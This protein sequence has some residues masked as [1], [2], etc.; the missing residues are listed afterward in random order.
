[1]KHFPLSVQTRQALARPSALAQT[2]AP[3]RSAWRTIA[4]LILLVSGAVPRVWAADIRTL[5]VDEHQGRY[6][7]TYDAIVDAARDDVYATIT[8]PER[9]PQLS[10]VVTAARVTG[11]LPDGGREISVTLHTCILIFCQ[12]LHKQEALRISAGGNIETVVFPERSDFSYAYEH[13]QISG[14]G[15]RTRIR[16]HAEMTPKFYIVPLIGSYLLKAKIR[17][18]LQQVTASLEAQ[19]AP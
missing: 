15:R 6:T 13:W 7:V 3:T 9:W 4:V 19:A 18:L 8:N 2:A 10:H 1:M 14:E 16:Y 11:K 5:K 17:S 12:T